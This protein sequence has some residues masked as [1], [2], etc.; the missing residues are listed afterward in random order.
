MT[1]VAI[2]IAISQRMRLSD[3]VAEIWRLK[4]NWVTTL[5]F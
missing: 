1:L 2:Y 5:N 3:T 4:H